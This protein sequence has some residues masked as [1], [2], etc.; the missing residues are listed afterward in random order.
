LA[1]F[2]AIGLFVTFQISSIATIFGHSIISRL[3]FY[4]YW[5]IMQ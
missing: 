3:H 4:L 2:I 1:T 5:A